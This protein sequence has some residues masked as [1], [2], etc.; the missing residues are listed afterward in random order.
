MKNLGYM[1]ERILSMNILGIFD[2]ANKVHKKT[3]RNRLLLII[4]IVWCGLR[5]MAGYVDYYVF[6]MYNLNEHQRRTVMTRGRNNAFIRELNNPKFKYI[7]ESKKAFHTQFSDL[8]KREWLSLEDSTFVEFSK[9]VEK[10]KDILVKSNTF[11]GSYC[12][13]KITVSDFDDLYT[14][15]YY[16]QDKKCTIIEDVFK[17]HPQLQ[18]LQPDSINSIRFVTIFTDEKIHIVRAYLRIGQSRSINDFDGRKMV[19]PIDIKTGIIHDVAVD[20]EGHYYRQHPLTDTK[21]QGFHIPLWNECLELVN[22]AASRV[23]QVRLVGWDIGISHEGPLL[24]E[25]NQFPC[26]DIYQLPLHTPKKIGM[27]PEFQEIIKS[28]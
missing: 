23:D 22:D 26:H 1:L 9:F 7:F 10:R 14:L 24:I 13:E 12:N 5:H 28:K 3:K 17:Q 18:Q 2:V 4:D 19:V 15:W 16:L 6:E 25:G 8:V 27:V 11:T 21:I 20:K